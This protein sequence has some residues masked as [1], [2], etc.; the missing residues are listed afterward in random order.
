MNKVVKSSIAAPVIIGVGI[1]ST[2][3]NALKRSSSAPNLARIPNQDEFV[4]SKIHK[5]PTTLSE[6]ERERKEAQLRGERYDTPDPMMFVW[7]FTNL[8]SI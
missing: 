5:K 8:D 1:A 4:S 6:M 3:N 2:V 7:D